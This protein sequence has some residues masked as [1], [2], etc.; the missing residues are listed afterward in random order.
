M[1]FVFLLTQSLDSPSGLGRFGPIARELVQQGHEVDL[2]AL[3]YDW[4][5]HQPKRFVD[6]GVRVAYVGQMHVRKEGSSKS[7]FGTGQLLLVTLMS[8]LR[9]TS[10]LR[11]LTR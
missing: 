1:K 7:Y 6:H 10:A 11:S 2:F 4:K 3:H 9:L 8:T 5:N